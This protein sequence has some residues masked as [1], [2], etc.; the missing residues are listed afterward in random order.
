MLFT[1]LAYYLK[2]KENADL[3][4]EED[5]KLIKSA[6]KQEEFLQWAC[7]HDFILLKDKKEFSDE[8]FRYKWMH[9]M[10]YRIMLCVVFM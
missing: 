7:N 3:M 9:L 5:I 6:E 10:V 1:L 8:E 2:W 4:K